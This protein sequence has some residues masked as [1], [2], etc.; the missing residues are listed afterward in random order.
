[1]HEFRVWAPTPRRVELVDHSSFKWTDRD[2]RGVSL[3]GAVVP[4]DAVA[5]V[6]VGDA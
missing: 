2:W 5:V 6:Q 1:M 3:P 4:P